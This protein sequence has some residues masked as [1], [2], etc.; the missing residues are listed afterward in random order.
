MTEGTNLVVGT[1]PERIKAEAK[2]I[3]DGKGKHGRCPDLWDGRTS[4]R[5]AALY[6]RV[7]GV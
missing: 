5:I 1:D 3:L 2:K 4:E 7:L 6:E